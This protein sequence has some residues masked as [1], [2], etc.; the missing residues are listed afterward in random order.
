VKLTLYRHNL[1]KCEDP[2]LPRNNDVI[3]GDFP[4]HIQEAARFA[5]IVEYRDGNFMRILKNK[6][7]FQREKPVQRGK[8]I[9][10][11]LIDTKIRQSL[12]TK[13]FI[14]EDEYGIKKAILER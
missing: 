11:N 2:N 3:L 1:K 14:Q 13:A 10:N 6:G 5:Q 7:F 9:F 12:F 4:G 8:E